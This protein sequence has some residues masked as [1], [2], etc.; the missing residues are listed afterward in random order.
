[1]TSTLRVGTHVA[2]STGHY[3]ASVRDDGGVI[4]ETVFSSPNQKHTVTLPYAE[5]DR[6]VAWVEW[7]R[8]K[9]LA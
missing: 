8:K 6:L 5:W 2:Y 4:I 1:M 9:T 7:R 3:K